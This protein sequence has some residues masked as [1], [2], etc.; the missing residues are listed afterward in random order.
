MSY[1]VIFTTLR[2]KLLIQRC[3]RVENPGEGVAQFV[4]KIWG[5]ARLSGKIAKEGSPI[6]GFIAFSLLLSLL[7][8]A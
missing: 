8:F 3:T 5:G 4:A 6:L 1:D 7:K 2:Q